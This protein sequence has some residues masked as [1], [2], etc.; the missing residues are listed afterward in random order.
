MLRNWTPAQLLTESALLSLH[1]RMFSEVWRWAGT[2]RRTDTNIGVDWRLIQVQLRQLVDDTS[3][4]VEYGSYP[5]DEI[6][7][8]FHH[9]LV[10]IHPFLNGNRRH[11]R[12]A[13][14]ILAISLNR[15]PFSWGADTLVTNRAARSEYLA[16]LRA[17]DVQYGYEGL[18]R[19]ARS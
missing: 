8:R 7:V 1:R 11:A 10:A 2:W 14:D 5:N 17:A 9:K 16:A 18:L 13:A 3:V 4:W 12:L 15:P 19:F 6:A